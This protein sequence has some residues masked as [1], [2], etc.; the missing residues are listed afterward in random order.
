VLAFARSCAHQ[1]VDAGSVRSRHVRPIHARSV[2]EGKSGPAKPSGKHKECV[3]ASQG[4]TEHEQVPGA[5]ICS[6]YPCAPISRRELQRDGP[7]IPSSA[8]ENVFAEGGLRDD[9]LV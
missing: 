5:A 4:R 8:L 9:D 6:R 1:G 2:Y 3:Q 7:V